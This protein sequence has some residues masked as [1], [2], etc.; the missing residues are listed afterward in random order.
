MK[1]TNGAKAGG[2]TKAQRETVREDCFDC[3]GSL[4]RFEP[5]FAEHMCVHLEAE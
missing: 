3:E 4:V 2:I 1:D 5:Q